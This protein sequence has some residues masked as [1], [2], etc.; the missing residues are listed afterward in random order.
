MGDGGALNSSLSLSTVLMD[1]FLS[2]SRVCFS[3][4]I[5]N[6]FIYSVNTECSLHTRHCSKRSKF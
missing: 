4:V 1:D 5:T 2:E 6:S 3:P